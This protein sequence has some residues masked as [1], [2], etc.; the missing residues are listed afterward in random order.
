MKNNSHVVILSIMSKII[1]SEQI[2]NLVEDIKSITKNIT[3]M[4]F[5]YCIR[6]LML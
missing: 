4:K 2:S 1:T 5:S 3:N 6:Q